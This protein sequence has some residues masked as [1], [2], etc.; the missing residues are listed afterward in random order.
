ML[1]EEMSKIRDEVQEAQRIFHKK[2][3]TIGR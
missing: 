2:N 1:D 3:K